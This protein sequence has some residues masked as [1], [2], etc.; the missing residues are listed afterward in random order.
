MVYQVKPQYSIPANVLLCTLLVASSLALVGLVGCTQVAN[1]Q[2]VPRDR[3]VL[4]PR[5]TQ[6]KYG[7]GAYTQ[8][9][10]RL[11]ETLVLPEAVAPG[12]AEARFF[13]CSADL[14][15][16]RWRGDSFVDFCRVSIMFVG[17]C[18]VPQ[19]FPHASQ[20]P[21]I[22]ILQCCIS[23]MRCTEKSLVRTLQKITCKR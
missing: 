15:R 5:Q 7:C 9:M 4:S 8:V 2:L 19:I 13:Y 6:T 14:I 20:I 12:A 22:I 16:W 23:C 11:E 3:L 21:L 1:T 18:G 17:K 10:L